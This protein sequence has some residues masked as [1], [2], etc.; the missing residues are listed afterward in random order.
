VNNKD[1]KS[2]LGFDAPLFPLKNPG[3]VSVPLGFLAAI[4]G[5]LLFRDRRAEEMFNEIYVRQN[6]GI[7]ISKAVDH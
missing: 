2:M 7:G 1:G 5:C 6:T 3:I 4:F